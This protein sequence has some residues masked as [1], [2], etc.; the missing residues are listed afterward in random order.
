MKGGETRLFLFYFRM[1]CPIFLM[2]KSILR[3]AL[4]LTIL[5]C[6][7]SCDQIS[8]SIVRESIGAYQHISVIPDHF[9]LM[10]VE[11]TGAFLSVGSELP[12]PI[13]LTLLIVLPV[14]GLGMMLF[15]LLRKSDWPKDFA[16]GV[17]FILGGGIGNLYDRVVYGSVTDFM[18][19]NFVVFQTGVFNM[20]DVS[21]MIGFALVAWSMFRGKEFHPLR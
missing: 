8:K 20:A 7:V 19:M 14:V 3:I 21:I 6:N 12:M 9:T 4:L 2:K 17:A 5:A 10:K 16:I 15:M 13:R 18:H 1:S 11:N